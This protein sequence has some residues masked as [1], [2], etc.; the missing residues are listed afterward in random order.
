VDYQEALEYISAS[1]RFGIKMGLERTRALLDAMGAPDTGLRG[2]LVGGTNGKGSTCAYLVACL[3]AAGYRVG[4]MPKP[5]LQSYTERI[6]VDGVPITEADF[7]AVVEDLKPVVEAVAV[8]DGHPTEFEMLTTGAIRYLREREV[9]YLVC[10]VGM[11][12]RL[13]STNVLDLGVKVV[14]SV[15]LDHTRY[16]GDTVREIAGEKAGIIRAGDV[17]VTGA[18]PPEADEVVR[19]RAADVGAEVRGLGREMRMTSESLGWRGSAF[20]VDAGAVSASR[21]VSAARSTSTGGLFTRLLGDHQAANAAVAVG[22]LGAMTERH[23]TRIGRGVIGRGLLATQWPGRLELLKGRPRIL[24]DGGHN[25]AAIE[26][27]VRAVN[28]LVAGQGGPRRVVALF[29]A[30]ADKDWPGMLQLLPA[31][32]PV[33]FTAVDED[34]AVK[35]SDL[36]AEADTMGREQAQSVDGSAAALEAARTAAGSDGMVLVLGS[37][38]LAG[39]VRTALGL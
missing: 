39:E 34:R 6:Q 8:E 11:G 21:S 23:G 5:H 14:T 15:D 7:A 18:L 31:E 19:T 13:D 30:M 33:V 36:L 22:A 17:V 25:P 38:Y 10:E 3:M 26:A 4:S 12:G 24:I 1:G 37:L 2:V 29:G 32:W 35:P 28:S 27:V 9:D 16:L 20:T